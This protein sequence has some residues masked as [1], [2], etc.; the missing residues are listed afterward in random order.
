MANIMRL[1]GGV[2]GGGELNVAYGLTPPSDT[3]KLWVRIADKP[4]SVTVQAVIPF[5]NEAVTAYGVST[6]NNTGAQGLAYCNGLLY[7]FHGY[8]VYVY[9]NGAWSK[10]LTLSGN[11]TSLHYTAPSVVIG[12]KIFRLFGHTN[13]N[14]HGSVA[15]ASYS[16]LSILIIDTETKTYSQVRVPNKT[17]FFQLV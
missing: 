2:G 1:G 10:F 9:E 17:S 15:N 6:P 14:A 13:S 3:S 7:I 16:S 11:T 8:D 5:G 12:K 4:N